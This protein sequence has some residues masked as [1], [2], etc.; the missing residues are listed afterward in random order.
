MTYF[1]II[2]RIHLLNML[3]VNSSPLSNMNKERKIDVCHTLKEPP[4]ALK[5]ILKLAIFDYDDRQEKIEYKVAIPSEF[6]S[7]YHHGK[8]RYNIN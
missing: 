5:N 2:L 8:R 6:S 1:I 7:K 4:S 3:Y